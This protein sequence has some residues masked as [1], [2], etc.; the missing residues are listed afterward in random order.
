MTPSTFALDAAAGPPLA[1]AKALVGGKAAN[2][3]VMVARARP[4]GA[5]GLRRSRPRPAGPSCATAGR[6]ASTTSCATR[7]AEVEA[8]VGRRFGDP[9]DPLL[10]SV[11]SGAPVSMP[12]MMDTI[13]DLGLNDATTAGLATRS[14]RRGVRPTLSRALRGELPLDRR[15]RRRARRTRGSSC[16]WRSRPSSARGTATAPARTA[17]QGGHPGRPRDGRDRP[18]DGLRQPRPDSATGVA[19]HAQPGDRR[20]DAVRRRAVRRPGRGRRG[21]DAPDRADRR[22]RRAAARR[23]RRAARP[24]R[25]GWSG[26]TPTCATS[27]SRSRTAG[28]GCSRS[29]SASAARRRRCGS[30]S[31]WPRTPTFPLVAGGGGRARRRRCSPIRRRSTSAPQ[32]RPSCRSRPAC[33]RRRA[34]ASGPIVTSPEAAAG[35]GRRGRAGDPRPGRDLARR[36]PR[37]GPGGRHPD[38]ARR[39]RE[40]RRGRGPRL[41]HPGRRRGRRRSRS[42]TAGSIVGDRIAASRRRHH[43]RRQHRRGLR[44]HHRR[45]ARGR[46]RGARRCSPGRRSSGSRSATKRPAT[47]LRPARRS[48]ATP[49]TPIGRKVTPDDCLRAIAI[50][51]F[52]PLQGRRRRR[53]GDARRRPADPRPAG[54]RRARRDRRR[55]AIG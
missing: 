16:A 26:T 33:R 43:H 22:A 8:A 19:L 14:R 48:A 23:R 40:P 10:V 34:S 37:H 53:A 3:G 17:Q 46:A 15:R 30:R 4:A 41:G 54:H 27:S 29:G 13:L 31:T 44:G 28:S 12:G 20:A 51:G 55:R 52:A 9:A 25:R 6:R 18:G 50:K 47:T 1:E 49:S 2:L 42:A 11:R 38:L 39:P 5:A 36:R 7:M 21:G 32:Q 24:R 35:R 45:D